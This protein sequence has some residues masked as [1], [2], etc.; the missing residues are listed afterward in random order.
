MLKGGDLCFFGFKWAGNFAAYPH[1]TLKVMFLGIAT[2]I[3]CA[4]ERVEHLD[5]DTDSH[6]KFF[7]I[8]CLN[9]LVDA[10]GLIS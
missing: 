6:G 2:L 3:V 5:G 1:R 10:P 7:T 8:Y 9:C 4:A